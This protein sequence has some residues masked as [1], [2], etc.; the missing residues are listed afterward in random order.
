M[1]GYAPGTVRVWDGTTWRYASSDWQVPTYESIKAGA[2]TALMPSTTTCTKSANII[3]AGSAITITGA[4]TGQYGTLEFYHR[5]G[6]GAWVLL[7]TRARPPTESGAVSISHAPTVSG[8]SYYVRFTGSPFSQA[9][10][11]APTLAVTVQTLKSMSKVCPLVWARAYNGA[12]TRLTG[13]G[14]DT[15][16]HQG[17]YS[18]TYGNRKSLLRFV[19]ALPAGATVTKV[20]L[21]CSAGWMNWHDE[22][23]GTIVVGSF[24]NQSTEPALW[25]VVATRPDRSRKTVG[26]G[27]W[28]IDLTG[29]AAAAVVSPTFSGLTIGPGPTTSPE[30]FGYSV[31]APAA[32]FQ[33]RIEHKSWS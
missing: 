7:A 14:R 23:S 19:P 3:H 11:S 15:A 24:S 12:G 18:A 20:T 27:S 32:E 1:S 33:L 2:S 25:D 28:E 22:D 30:F 16:I 9:S 6:A 21:S 4:T 8:T 10:S 26:V 31:D 13:S 5:V 17:Y 29:W